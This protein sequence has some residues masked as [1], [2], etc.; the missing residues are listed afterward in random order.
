MRR[1][2]NRRGSAGPKVYNAR[3]PEQIRAMPFS[4]AA[5]AVQDAKLGLG[6]Q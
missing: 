1:R 4:S 3:V 6:F 5:R 2:K